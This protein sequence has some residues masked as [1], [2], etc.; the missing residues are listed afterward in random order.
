MTTTLKDQISHAIGA[1]GVWKRRLAEAVQNGKSE[2]QS[3]KVEV[4]NACDF[5]K[6]LHQ[7]IDPASKT[8][9]SYTAVKEQHARFHKEAAKVLRLVE[10]GKLAEAKKVLEGDYATISSKLVQMLILWREK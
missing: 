7:T 10:A 5:G 9:A 3:A 8:H 4:D 2:F 6:W 1:H